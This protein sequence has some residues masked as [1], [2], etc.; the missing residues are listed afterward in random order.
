MVP[1]M[2]LT[3]SLQNANITLS[4]QL[5]NCEDCSVVPIAGLSDP[6]VGLQP[7]RCHDMGTL[8]V[9]LAFATMAGQV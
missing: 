2:W 6:I 9:P 7:W 1:S 3:T 8:A 4:A 5:D